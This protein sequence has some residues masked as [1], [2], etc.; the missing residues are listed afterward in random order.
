MKDIELTTSKNIKLKTSNHKA[1]NY[2]E[3]KQTKGKKLR[4]LGMCI[5]REKYIKFV[6]FY[7]ESTNLE[8]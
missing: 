8:L 1:H 2:K 5:G 4:I 6:Q 7:Y 3:L